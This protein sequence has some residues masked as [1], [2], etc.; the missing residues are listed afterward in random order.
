MCTPSVNRSSEWL[1]EGMN[2]ALQEH[3]GGKETPEEGVT[4]A[5]LEG[6]AEESARA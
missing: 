4:A 1:M 6:E 3:K 5:L 2:V